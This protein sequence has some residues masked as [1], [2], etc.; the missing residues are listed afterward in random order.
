[1]RNIVKGQCDENWFY[2]PALN[3]CYRFFCDKRTW[4][5]ADAF[6]KKQ[7]QSGHMASVHSSDQN[8]FFTK[9]IAAVNIRNPRTWIG[10][11][12]RHQEG[13]FF[14]SDGSSSKYRN[15][16]EGEP[17]NYGRNEHCVERNYG[18][19]CNSVRNVVLLE[20]DFRHSIEQEVTSTDLLLHRGREPTPWVLCSAELD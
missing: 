3:S 16:L 12:D 7:K 9:V 6:C 8:T 5:E 17:N 14:W 15:W 11:N 13:K 19:E 4:S 18:R 1:M 20:V 10:L 2:F